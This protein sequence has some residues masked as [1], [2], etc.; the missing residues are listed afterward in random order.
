MNRIGEYRWV[1][2]ADRWMWNEAMF[3][4]LGHEP[5]D[6]RPS[7]DLVVARTH[8]GDRVRVELAI[9]A[10]VRVLG[11]YACRYRVVDVEHEVHEVVVVG[12]AAGEV[13]T[14]CVEL[15]G[16]VIEVAV[17]GE[18]RP[19]SAAPRP[20]QSGVHAPRPPRFGGRATEHD[21][22]L[23]RATEV[24]A[25]MTGVGLASACDLVAHLANR[26][27]EPP[28]V[29]AERIIVGALDPDSVGLSGLLAA[30]DPHRDD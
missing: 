4:I 11:T 23:T 13:R 24:L 16:F 15:R 20:P 14:G 19:S 30:I 12:R 22:I 2:S 25:D 10:A 6:V 28:V 9:T 21:R 26:F 17:G 5:G 3:R 7:R 1:P 29:V 27:A 8:P 18:Q